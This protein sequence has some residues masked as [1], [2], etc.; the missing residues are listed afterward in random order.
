MLKKSGYLLLAI[1]L[2]IQLGLV[3]CGKKETNMKTKAYA[4]DGLL[5]TTGGY[6]NIPTNPSFHTYANDRSLVIKALTPIKGILNSRI[7]FR[8][9]DLIVNLDLDPATDIETA[10]Q[11]KYAALGSVSQMMPR[12]RVKVNVGKTS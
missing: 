12:Y 4:N 10:M 11:I 7:M 3:G 6:P 5:G 9:P 8:G 2:I 1:L